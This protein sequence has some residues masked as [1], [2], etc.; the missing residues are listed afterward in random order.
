MSDEAPTEDSPTDDEPDGGGAH[1]GTGPAGGDDDGVEWDG[2]EEETGAPAARPRSMTGWQRLSQT[3]VTPGASAR[4]RPS[5][6]S[7]AEPEPIDFSSL[8]PKEIRTAINQINDTERRVGL[9][10]AGLA[11][12]VTVFFTVPYLVE[13]KPLTITETPTG[14]KCAAHFT[15]IPAKHGAAAVCQG[16]ITKGELSVIL[17]IGLV[18][19]AAIVV[20]VRLRRRAALAFA[21]AM[22]GLALTTVN[23]LAAL[24]FFIV[25]GWLVLRAYRTQKFGSPTAKSPVEGYVRPGPPPRG[26]A[27]AGAGPIT[28]RGSRPAGPAATTGRPRATGRAAAK[29]GDDTGA[30]KPPAPSKRYTPKAPPKKR[31]PPPPD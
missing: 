17:V 13:K 6:S 31:P 11:A 2:G 22:A 28:A 26:S 3:F 30:R 12:V 18:F 24:P 21:T 16:I 19:A 25:A 23:I 1:A 7:R 14:K 9:I 5:R 8:T 20:C 27:R 29:A 4:Q 10:A 15:Y